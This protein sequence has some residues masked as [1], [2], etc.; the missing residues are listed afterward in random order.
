M[1]SWSRLSQKDDD[2]HDDMVLKV[3]MLLI[4]QKIA[5]YSFGSASTGEEGDRSTEKAPGTRAPEGQ[6]GATGTSV[7]IVAGLLVQ[8]LLRSPA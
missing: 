3:M 6:R 1:V 7:T 8:H 4:L 5:N 2:E